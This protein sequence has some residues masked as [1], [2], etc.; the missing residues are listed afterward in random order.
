VYSSCLPNIG[1]SP[2]RYYRD[3]DGLEV[4]AIIELR[5]GRWGAIEIKLGANKVPEAVKSLCRLRDKVANNPA[6]R[7]PTPSFMAVLVGKSDL[8]YRTPEGVYVF[9]ITSLRP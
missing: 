9:P 2:L 4:D 5:D 6:A 3:S 8:R 7:N 1:P